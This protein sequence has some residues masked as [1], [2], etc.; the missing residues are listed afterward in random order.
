M[1]HTP[2]PWLYE[3]GPKG[4]P[5]VADAEFLIVEDRHHGEVIAT[6]ITAPNGRGTAEGNAQL[7]AE[8][9]DLFTHGRDLVQA[10]RPIHDAG[11]MTVAMQS[12]FRGLR[13]AVDR[14]AGDVIVEDVVE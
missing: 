5:D 1:A 11:H 6:I 7:I 14:A 13:G 4:D 8:A 12:A 3:P 2:G 9:P 10:L